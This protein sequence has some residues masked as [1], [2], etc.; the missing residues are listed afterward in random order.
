ML[1]PPLAITLL[2]GVFVPQHLS[3][4][5]PLRLQKEQQ[6]MTY[7]NASGYINIDTFSFIKSI[8]NTAQTIRP[9]L[10]VAPR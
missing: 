6:L 8:I 4:R 2:H 3:F 9:Y 10:K 5:H 7:L 1:L